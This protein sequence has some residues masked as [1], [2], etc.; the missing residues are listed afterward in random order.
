MEH[1]LRI[2]KC[3][4]WRVITM[5][6]KLSIC[7]RSKVVVGHGRFAQGHQSL[8]SLEDCNCSPTNMATEMADDGDAGRSVVQRPGCSAF[9]RFQG[10]SQTARRPMFCFRLPCCQT[11][12]ITIPKTPSYQVKQVFFKSEKLHNLHFTWEFSRNFKPFK[13]VGTD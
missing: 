10:Q 1:T 8:A 11:E 4:Q 5:I 12:P 3:K 6:R 9:P 2:K 7:A 13:S